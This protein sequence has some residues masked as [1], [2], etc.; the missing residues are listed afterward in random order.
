MD[1]IASS[2]GYLLPIFFIGYFPCAILLNTLVFKRRYGN[3]EHLI[4]FLCGYACAVI[5]GALVGW[6]ILSDNP[7]IISIITSCVVVT[8]AHLTKSSDAQQDDKVHN[9]VS[10]TD[11]GETKKCPFCAELIKFEALKCKHC[12]ERFDTSGVEDQIKQR[13][14]EKEREMFHNEYKLLHGDSEE[15]FCIGCRTVSA[16]NG[17]YYH[18]R[19]DTYYHEKCLQKERQSNA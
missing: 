12:G 10:N 1:M 16:K 3:L 15:A 5:I 2:I 13:N 6:R 11:A 17:M 4:M 7:F 14:A 9:T 18:R 19:T 8:L